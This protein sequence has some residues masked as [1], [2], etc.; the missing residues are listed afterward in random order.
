MVKNSLKISKINR[1]NGI[2]Y[3]YIYIYIYM[4]SVKVLL[5]FSEGWIHLLKK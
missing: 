3:I 1:K 2:I 5:G 4:E